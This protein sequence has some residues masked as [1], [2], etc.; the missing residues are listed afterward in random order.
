MFDPQ[1]LLTTVLGSGAVVAAAG[2]VLRKYFDRILDIRMST[3]QEQNKAILTEMSRRRAAVYDQLFD[4]LRTSA[5]LVYRARNCARD[6]SAH[7][8]HIDRKHSRERLEGLKAYHTAIEELL[9]EQRA[10]L[11]DSI[12]RNL[13]EMKTSLSA[14]ILHVERY[15]RTKKSEGE[16]S[17][18]SLEIQR[19][20]LSCFQQLDTQY[21]VLAEI[22]QKHISS[23]T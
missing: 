17:E 19:D 3:L 10:L 8:A 1:I 12:F 22:I 16:Q 11:P 2:Y 9:Y 7:P 14:F 21:A 13:H 4:V 5:S 18:K 23:D 20:I 6:I 15:R